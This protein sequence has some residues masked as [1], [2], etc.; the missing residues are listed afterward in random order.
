MAGSYR[1]RA[2][3]VAASVALAAGCTGKDPTR[4][5]DS[6][7][8]FGVTAAL[9][10]STCGTTPNPWTFDVRL[11]H[12]GTTLYWVQGQ[13]PIS[14]VVNAAGTAAMTTSSTDTV[15]AAT[16]TVSACEMQRDDAV[17]VT[18][19]PIG[20]GGKDISTATSFT[21]AL[22]YHFSA[23]SGADCSDQLAAVGGDYAALPCAIS[24]T[25][26]ATKTGDTN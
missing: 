15:R 24:Y 13:Q 22:T 10:A 6:I 14:A 11:R 25:L 8:V 26:T 16:S 20:Y 19:S 7:G 21:G 23:T 12:D 9:T 18:L 17:N 1:S 2:L 3:L 4:P 5:G